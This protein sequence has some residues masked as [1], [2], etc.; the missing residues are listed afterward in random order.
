MS[1]SKHA[2]LRLMNEYC[3]T[4]DS[5]DLEGFA[6]LFEHG[7]FGI[8]GDPG[9]PLQGHEAVLGMLQ[10][11][12]LYD[13]KTHTKHVMSNVQIDV[14]DARGAATAQCYI[15][16]FQGLPDFPLQPIFIGHYHDEFERVDGQWRFRSRSISPDLIGDLSRHRADMA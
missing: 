8:V 14:D 10:N 12:T 7:S 6:R 3:Y 5:G 4:V 9:G 2:I 11:V 15:T 1:D 16:V 13:G